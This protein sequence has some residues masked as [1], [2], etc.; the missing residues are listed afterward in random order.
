MQNGGSRMNERIRRWVVLCL[1]MSLLVCAG[2]WGVAQE[3][4]TSEDAEYKRV[5][6]ILCHMSG[7]LRLVRI[8]AS[9]AVLSPVRSDQRLYT[10]YIVNFLE[11]EHGEHY[12][13]LPVRSDLAEAVRAWGVSMDGPGL[14]ESARVLSA[15]AVRF[16][17]WMFPGVSQEQPIY[18]V[19]NIAFLLAAALEEAVLSLKPRSIEQAAD[20]MRRAYAYAFTALGGVGTG[21]N[22]GSVTGLLVQLKRSPSCRPQPQEQT[23]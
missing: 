19:K 8:L 14:N 2:L 3:D 22:P 20:H 16:N 13:A 5:I 17:R 6:A 4:A 9:Y 12:V 1:A 10:Q 7:H 18:E 11:G 23:D 15:S 21:V